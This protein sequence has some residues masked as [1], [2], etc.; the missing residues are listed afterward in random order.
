MSILGIS[1]FYHDAAA[2]LLQ[3]GRLVAAAEEE[4][5]TRQK[6]DSAFPLRAIEFCLERGNV[7]ASD[8]DYVV[9]YEKPFQ[10]RGVQGHGD[11]DMDYFSYHYS[12]RRTFNAKF[13]ALFGKP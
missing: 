1:C 3:E 8:L 7:R 2:A 6:H 11:G 10:R 9:F 13:E 4:R 5:F 12:S